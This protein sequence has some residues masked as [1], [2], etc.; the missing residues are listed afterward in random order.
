MLTLLDDKFIKKIVNSGLV[1]LYTIFYINLVIDDGIIWSLTII[2]ITLF[3]IYLLSNKKV[4]LNKYILWT[5]VL[6][7]TSITLN[8]LLFHSNQTTSDIVFDKDIKKTVWQFLFVIPLLLL[9]TLIKTSQLKLDLFYKIT[10]FATFS[11][12][13]FNTY[14]NIKTEFNRD[15]LVEKFSAIILYDYSIISLSLVSLIYSIQLKSKYSYLFI[16]LCLT[17]ILIIISHGSRGTWIGIP[18]IFLIIFSTHYK[19]YLNK[20]IFIAIFFIIIISSSLLIPNS[21]IIQRIKNFQQDQ[22]ILNANNFNS[23]TGARIALWNFSVSEFKES[24]LIGVG[25]KKFREDTCELAEKKIIPSCH[26]HAHNIFLQELATHGIFGLLSILLIFFIPTRYFLK[27]ISTSPESRLIAVSGIS[28]ITYSIFCGL[29]DYFFL[30]GPATLFFYLTTIS[31]MS[32]LAH[33]KD[34]KL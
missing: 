19:N 13:P 15:L 29:T 25:V 32:F 1:L 21:P 2:P 6:G 3:F 33:Y 34:L 16:T 23:S 30:S 9:P 24:P 28:I 20:L 31:L 22:I 14:W 26:Y 12:I 17:N 27:N 5:G 8:E 18:F 11:S 7:F 10:T 4:L